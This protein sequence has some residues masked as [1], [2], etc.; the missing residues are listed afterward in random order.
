MRSRS[1]QL[2]ETGISELSHGRLQTCPGCPVWAVPC[3]IPAGMCAL[4]QSGHCVLL[5]LALTETH[6]TPN[7][8]STKKLELLVYNKGDL[9]L[10]FSKGIFASEDTPEN[11]F[12]IINLAYAH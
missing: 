9:F 1:G 3:T 4:E 7:C 11:K 10:F 2:L 8:V 12:I 5:A 6:C